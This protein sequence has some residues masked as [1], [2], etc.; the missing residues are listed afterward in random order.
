MC[1]L[2]HSGTSADT[3]SSGF[4]PTSGVNIGIFESSLMGLYPS[5][6]SSVLHE[7][8]PIGKPIP[9]DKWRTRDTLSE[10]YIC[11]ILARNS[12]QE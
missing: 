8:S 2:S 6:V 9:L 3:C 4:I 1:L 10:Q 7:K 12:L 5:T 11:R